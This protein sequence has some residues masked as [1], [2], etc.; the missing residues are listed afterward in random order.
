ME[1]SGL[2]RCNRGASSETTS[3]PATY[4]RSSTHSAR[5]SG[6]AALADAFASGVDEMRSSL[7]SGIDLALSMM[8]M[9]SRLLESGASQRIVKT[10]MDRLFESRD[11][12]RFGWMNAVTSVARDTTDPELRWRLEEFGGG[13]PVAAEEAG[14]QRGRMIDREIDERQG[15]GIDRIPS[16]SRLSSL[17]K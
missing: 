12:S 16:A 15:E 13:I 8:P 9:M 6:R 14:R 5:R 11:T 7:Q 1:R 10:I 17:V 3:H 4:P 2:M